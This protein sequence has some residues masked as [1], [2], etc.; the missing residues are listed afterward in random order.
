M[1]PCGVCSGVRVCAGVRVCGCVGMCAGVR[2]ACVL[3]LVSCVWYL[4]P[5]KLVSCA[6][7]V[8]MIARSMH[9]SYL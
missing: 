7:C 6:L 9:R 3:D 1:W 8:V 5:G 4:L 2:C